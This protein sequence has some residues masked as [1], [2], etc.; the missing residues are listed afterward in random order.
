[1]AQAA[2][3]QRWDMEK[4][5]VDLR[6]DDASKE[7]RRRREAMSKPIPSYRAKLVLLAGGQAEIS[8]TRVSEENV[9]NARMGR[10]PL[11]DNRRKDRT[12]GQQ[13]E[14]DKENSKRAAKRARQN[15]RYKCKA[16]EADHMLTFSYRENVQERARVVADWEA[17]VR[18]FRVRYPEW[19]YLAVVEAQERGSLHLH[20]A[21]RGRQDIKWLLRCWLL[22]IGQD[23][24]DVIAWYVRGVAL[25]EKSLGAVNVEAPNKRWR[26][27]YEGGKNWKTGK[28][29]SYLSKY[30]GKDFDVG[31]K[32]DKRYW[33]SRNIEKPVVTRFW[34]SA[35]T[36]EAAAIEAFDMLYYRGMSPSWWGNSLDD[37]IWIEGETP[38]DRL[39]QCSEC[40]PDMDLLND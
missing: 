16:F 1:M 35:M 38:K 12:P 33:A 39:G 21:V 3:R 40:V 10:N 29:A 2:I 4:D 31:K 22:S 6:P 26:S 18:L 32:G 34:L 13:A 30:I 23:A 14:R 5:Q 9:I 24:D 19:Q 8:V 28:L 27:D 11:L 37:V 15:V 7:Y 20:V 36:F 17:F 25:G